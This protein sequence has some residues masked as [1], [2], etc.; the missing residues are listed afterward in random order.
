MYKQISP[1]SPNKAKYF[2]SI[3]ITGLLTVGLA[4]SLW[5]PFDASSPVV[6]SEPIR[7]VDMSSIRC[8]WATVATSESYGETSSIPSSSKLQKGFLV[9]PSITV[10][11]ATHPHKTSTWARAHP[12]IPG[13]L[14]H[15]DQCLEINR[16][17]VLPHHVMLLFWFWGIT[18]Y[19]VGCLSLRP[20]GL[21]PVS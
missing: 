17:Q 10:T 4:A 21:Q 14:H 2:G 11:P 12:L 1:T 5:P 9:I 13:R 20:L 7:Q 6:Q 19:R 15:S 8:T 16:G 3:Y 18:L